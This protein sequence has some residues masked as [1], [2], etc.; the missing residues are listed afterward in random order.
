MNSQE[1][2]ERSNQEREKIFE[3]YELGRQG[4]IDS[5]EDPEFNVY[6]KIDRWAKASLPPL[7]NLSPTLE[8]FPLKYQ[9]TFDI[10][11]FASSQH[12][13]F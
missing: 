1:L 2:L 10:L 13:N 5:W 12:I 8:L 7:Q 11:Q 4:P 9:A 6:S 3:R